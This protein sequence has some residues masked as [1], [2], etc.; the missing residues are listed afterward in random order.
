LLFLL[1]A[2]SICANANVR[3]PKL[4][5][6][7]M[8]LQRNKLIPVW[9]WADANEKIEIKFNKQTKTTKA[10]KN[11]KWIIRLD[12]EN[13]GGPYLLSIKGKNKIVVK[14][15]LV[16]EVW[17]CSGQSNMAFTVSE[18]ANAE[19]EINAANYPFI[20]EFTVGR[21]VSSLPKN[22]LKEGKWEVC[23]KSTVGNFTAVGYFFAKKIY[24]ELKIPIGLIHTSWG[25][26]VSE[27]WTSREAFESSDEFKKMITEMPNV[28]LD[29]ISKVFNKSV[30]KRVEELQ[31]SKID[32]AK[33][34][35]FKEFAFNDSAWPE[36]NEPEA[37]ESQDLGEFDGIVWLRKTITLSAN[38]A[39]KEATIELSKIDDEDIS[40]VNGVEV[41]R[42]D[43]WDARRKYSIPAGILK[44]GKNTIS[45]RV[46]DGGGG[47]GIYDESDDFKLIIGEKIIPLNGKWK[48]QVES[49]NS[50]VGPNSYPSL[51]FNA[52]VNPLIPYAFEGVLW[53]QGESNAWRAQQY[54]KAF[55]LLIND[56]RKKWNQGDFPFYFVQISS[57]NETNGNSNNGSMWAELRE[58][59]TQTLKLPNTGMCVTTD[60]GNPTNIH[61]TNKQDVGKRLAAIALKNIYNQNIVCT[62]PTYK[63]MEI[64]GNKIVVSFEN[65]GSGLS[66]PDKYG[67]LKG[68]EIAGEDKVFHYANAQIVN[69]K[70]IIYN[71]N[72]TNP[73]AVHLGWADD[74]SDNNLYNKQ[75]FPAEPFRTDNWK[76][77]TDAM[78]YKIVK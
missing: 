12:A 62:G 1:L 67:C 64:Q 28:N 63:S 33:A 34:E 45:I 16:G 65:I 40:Y 43:N 29:S 66:T 13:A 5:A 30:A 14:N 78:E 11:G 36:L 23:N 53:Y 51:L 68:F 4:F 52:M 15:V 46:V 7:D 42:N 69:N 39:G 73:V 75:G 8:V 26:T 60:I 32:P 71:E 72:V 77:V 18:A 58:A 21:D 56:W 19:K 41:G 74:A 76:N 38:D 6:D 55:P 59:Q 49:I 35:M 48:Y 27:T 54:K 47:G 22:D 44:E 17:I 10:D 70:V 37:W 3:L 25:G 9:G 61:P 57:F 2:F 24:S 50:E 20:R 31:G